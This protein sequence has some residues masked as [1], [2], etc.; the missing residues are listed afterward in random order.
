MASATWSPRTKFEPAATHYEHGTDAPQT[1]G[2]DDIYAPHGLTPEMGQQIIK[3]IIHPYRTQWAT[4]R[5]TKM[6]NWLKAIEFDKGRQV[7]GWDPTT[8]TYFDAVAYY[9]QNNQGEDYA[10]LE[11]YTNN[12]TQTIRRN[13][14]AAVCRAVPP[15][16][17]RPENAENLAD[18]TTA[19]A[20]QEAWDIIE[21]SNDAKNQLSLEGYDLYIFGVYFKRTKFKIDGS[22]AGYKEEQVYGDVEAE[23][24]SDHF[25]CT[26]CGSDTDANSV[27]FTNPD[28]M[29]CTHCSSQIT[30]SD[31][32]PGEKTTVPGVVGKKKTPKGMVE[33][34]V[35]NPLMIDTDP[36]AEC[37]AD[38]DLLALEY[39][40]NVASLR[41]AYPK[42]KRQINEGME[43]A[44]DDNASYDRLVRTMVFSSNYNISGDIF[45]ERSTWTKVWIQPVAYDRSTDDNFVDAMNKAFPYG[46]AVSMTGD[47]I[48]DIEAAVLEKEWT[49]CKLHDGY[50]MY[51]PTVADNVV[52]FNERFNNISNILDNYMERCSTGMTLIDTRRLDP[53]Q[54]NG[55]S[56]VGSDLNPVS[57]IGEGTKNALSDAIYHFK[58]ELD[59]NIF[60][61][62]DR[63]WNYCQ[64]ISGV[65]PQVAGTG[66]TKGV[67]TAKGQA[68]MLDQAMGSLGDIYDRIKT[69][70]AAAAQNAIEC[71]QQNMA[72]MGDIWNVIEENGSEFR[73]NYVHLD[74]MQG[75][76][77]V[78]PNIDEG[79]P[80]SPEQKRQ[81]CENIMNWAEKNNPA[82]IAW[83]DEVTNQELLNDY[84][85]LPG[86]V[87][88]GHAQMSKTS[89][90]IS[91]LLKSKP[92][93]MFG[94]DGQPVLDD[95]GTQRMQPSIAPDKWTEDYTVLRA[96]I[97]EF[98][99]TNADTKDANPIGWQ[100][101]IAFYRMAC[102]YEA[103]TN[104][105]KA[106]LKAKVAAAGVPPPPPGPEANPNVQQIEA[107]A[108][109][110]AMINIDRLTQ[111]AALPPLP[112]GSTITGQVSAA[113]ESVNAVEKMLK[114]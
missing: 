39:E 16:I 41:N 22:W 55:K 88:P 35:F 98:C 12:I 3:E 6:V 105:Y 26:S 34:R 76:V 43:S 62:L 65:P 93:P 57:T 37:I 89:Q 8:R 108:I 95:D 51:P 2:E 7:L 81:W 20:A 32:M 106:T 70:H 31:F 75:R 47:L 102:E 36:T 30:P 46:C 91:K 68:Q 73:N 1:K 100:N 42:M 58:F 97:E 44:T 94:P 15:V 10:Y 60:N 56:L 78:Y 113:S 111:L 53:T 63:L 19:K 23:L 61:Y 104:A 103:T 24:S 82:A 18:M 67:E 92:I 64:L 25:H 114:Q 87:T 33:Q 109:K 38:C 5:I 90:D 99:R 85:G 74:E 27:D 9:R 69:E 48:L 40:V 49:A 101:V 29:Q 77:R 66:T 86:S 4:N 59:A 84:W 52:P 13:F 14:T 21:R 112:Q 45:S 50:G 110:Q 107:E 96:T 11:K 28:G 17:I 80:M 71:F 54:L 83:L 72:Y 79:L